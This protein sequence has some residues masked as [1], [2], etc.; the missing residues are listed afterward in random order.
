MQDGS[1]PVL[2]PRQIDC[3]RLA[4]LGMTS[5]QIAR[6]LG[7][8]PRTV[9]QHLTLACA[10]LGVRNRTPAVARA[11]L[12]GIISDVSENPEGSGTR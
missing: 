9:D 4:A 6:K 5:A 7:M 12:L 11:V 8:A 2:S 3:L 1:V 10:R